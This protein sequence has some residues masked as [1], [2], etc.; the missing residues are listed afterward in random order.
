MRVTA[1]SLLLCLACTAEAA[2]MPVAALPGGMLVY[3]PVQSV[4]ER[5]FSD[6]VEQKNRFQLRRRRAGHG[7]APGLLA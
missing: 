1:V 6:I 2:Q 5:K 7:A 3:K 4:R